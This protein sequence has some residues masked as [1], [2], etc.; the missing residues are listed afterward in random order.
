M[1]DGFKIKYSKDGPDWVA[2]INYVSEDGLTELSIAAIQN[3]KE[4][5][6]EELYHS[7]ETLSQQLNLTK[8]GKFTHSEFQIKK[9]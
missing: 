9:D 6:L 4:D 1:K 5:A 8:Y 2:Q 7:I 3:T